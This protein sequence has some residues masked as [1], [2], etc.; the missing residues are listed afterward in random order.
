MSTQVKA[1]QAAQ[2]LYDAHA[3]KRVYDPL[4]E[5][6]SPQTIDEAYQLQDEFLGLLSG[7]YGQL[8]GYKLAY[9]T[10]AMQERAG[11]AEPCAGGLL[12]SGIRQ[13]PAPLDSNDFLKLGVE[14]EI[15]VELGLELAP[16]GAPYTRDKVAQAV[17]AVM[18]AFE[19][20]DFRTPELQGKA[21]ALTAISTNISNAGVVLGKRVSDW[22]GLDLAAARGAL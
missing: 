20:V 19:V 1:R 12:S 15:A 4:P 16:A 21:R 17:A 14:C 2:L 11:L 22:R 6:L 7:L 3:R 8:A 10:S 9:T 13:S 5:E 18:P